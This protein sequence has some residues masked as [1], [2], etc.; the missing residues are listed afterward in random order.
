MKDRRANHEG[1]KPIRRANGR[2][3][4]SVQINGKRRY[5]SGDTASAARENMRAWLRSPAAADPNKIEEH[6]TVSALLDSYLKRI[7]ETKAD[8]TYRSYRGVIIHHIKPR[9]GSINPLKVTPRHINAMLEDMRQSPIAIAGTPKHGK[10]KRLIGARTC[11]LAYIVVGAAFK[12]IIPGL[13]STVSKPKVQ[14]EEMHPWTSD[15]AARF[16][17]YVDTRRRVS[18]ALPSSSRLR[19]QPTAHPN[20]QDVQREARPRWATQGHHPHAEPS[21]SRKRR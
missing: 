13:L 12:A 16:L 18:R 8:K 1:S 15:E 6:A 5:F 10:A 7:K 11:E 17:R 3:Q 20:H 19:R 4:C 21:L 2:Y 14:T 9:I